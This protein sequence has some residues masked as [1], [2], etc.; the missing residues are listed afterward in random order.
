[1]KVLGIDLGPSSIGWAYINEKS[2]EI[3]GTGVRIFSEG[4]ENLGD[5][6]REI[7]KNAS[8]TENRGKRRQF[9]RKRLRKLILLN[10]LCEYGM[11]P[12]QK[13]SLRLWNLEEIA[14]TEQFK[15]W[16]RL[17]PYQLRQQALKDKISLHELGRIF[18]HM[19]QRRG[20][21]SNSRS[22]SKEAGVI[23]EGKAKDDKIGIFETRK[24]IKGKTLGSYLNELYP[25]PNTSYSGEK[26][27]IRNRYTSRSMYIE[28][29]EQIWDKQKEYHTELTD[30]IKE[31]IGGRKKD[32]YSKD[33]VLFHQRP[34][35]S[36][37]KLI[38]KCTFEP[39]KTKCPASAIPFEY[40]KIYQWVN[41]VECDGI[42]LSA[43]ERK[44]LVETLLRKPKPTFK[45]LRK[46]IGK[47]D[48]L[49]QFNYKDDDKIGGSNTVSTLC[50]KKFW[51]EKWFQLSD[52]EQEEIW[53]D[54]YFYDDKEMLKQRAIE[55]WGFDEDK[56]EAISKYNL[57][58]GYAN[59]SR[60]AISNILPFLKMGFLYHNAVTLGGIKNVFGERWET[61]TNEE[62][63]LI[64]D[65]IYDITRAGQKGGYIHLLKDFLRIEFNIDEKHL[66]R[67]YH[68]SA[69]IKAGDLLKKLPIGKEADK[70][71]QS[72]R[73]P[74]VIKALFELRK[75]INELIDR[76]GSPDRINIE[77]ARDLKVSKQKRN[78]IRRE[79]KR[80][81]RE[82]DRVKDELNKLGQVIS[83]DNML[84]YKLWEECNR[85][86]PFTGKEISI[87]ELFSG[88]V[89]IEHIL[90]WSKSLNDSF[91]NKTLCFADEN[92]AKGN[93]TPYEFYYETQGEEKWESIKQQALSCFKTKA[94]YPNAYGKFKQFIKKEYDD[95]F[96]SRHLNDTRYIS[97]E[98]KS[99]LAKIC[100]DVRVSPGQVTSNLRHKWGL[101]SI[102]ND[103]GSKTRDDHRHHAIDALVMACSKVSYL[104][105]L[106]R[107]N[108]YNRSYDTKDFPLPWPS[109]R[110][111]A[112]KSV[113]SILVSHKKD[114]RVLTRR[115]YRVR[116]KGKYYTNI[117]IAARG[118]LHKETVFGKRKPISG[119]EAYHI[120][121][122]L[123]SITTAKQVDKIVDP[124]IRQLVHSRVRELGGYINGKTVPEGTFFETNNQGNKQPKIFL[125][126]K[127]GAPVPV[128]KVR[129][130]ENLSG[131]E[132]LKDENQYVNLR[133]NH[134]VL[135][136]EDE[137]GKL[138]EEVVT[139]WTAVE[140]VKQ[141][142]P[143]Y[144]LPFDGGTILACL[145]RNDMYIMSG[146]MEN[147]ENINIRELYDFEE[148]SK[149]LYK[150]EAVSSKYYE[151]RH[152]KEST[153]N[154]SKQP[155]YI[156]IQSFGE[157]KTG[158][159]KFKPVKV[160]ISSS[161]KLELAE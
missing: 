61:L 93:R 91:M 156:R 39:N 66:N 49:F 106:S 128:L 51:G 27:R 33:G 5:G 104:Q 25:E 18:Y 64:T 110:Y 40:F 95:D 19:L 50:S 46:V 43:P 151:F 79:Q 22:A 10:V 148:V 135:V 119:T 8:R 16:V 56:A 7:S 32:G 145:E 52:R 26:E 78:D 67:L 42:R 144:Q 62:K 117:G 31:Q 96:T 98:A 157:G 30:E 9:F 29:F 152:H 113:N 6:Q 47:E 65:N 53:H 146:L 92:R 131:A 126:N 108:R 12:V 107:W 90:P 114:N 120:R 82:N 129:M 112:E 153:Q 48:S 54:L 161:G 125:P 94:N 150:L 38:G 69:N 130:K 13:N 160:T 101:N 73:N 102:L 21:Q 103:E 89:Q 36:Q 149:Y 111:D 28:E 59:L 99:Y 97:K 142:Q 159:K 122:S 100:K 23:F 1:M 57:V 68:H 136:Y 133:N 24:K 155:N 20:F 137:A 72:I 2:S 60:K 105:E 81:E 41:T 70:E 71:I 74:V 3:L 127:K 87:T 88:A 115:K 14:K 34:L 75:V 37:K 11:C 63:S 85:T 116:K 109:F 77:L 4:V 76:F 141:K 84:K 83:H 139:F 86:C 121:K 134:H 118:A 80:L 143:L 154:N 140:R 58:D 17:N 35:R 147:L 132:R 15:E 55:K 138:K 45:Q 44:K 124:V 158:W 123:D